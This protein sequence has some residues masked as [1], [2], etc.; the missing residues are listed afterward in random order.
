MTEKLGQKIKML[1]K[2]GPQA[3]QLEMIMEAQ[4][5]HY[6]FSFEILSR[7]TLEVHSSCHEEP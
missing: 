4:R 3:K 6:V 2:L 5:L 1:N 7:Q